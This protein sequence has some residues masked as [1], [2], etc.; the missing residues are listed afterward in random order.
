VDERPLDGT[1]KNIGA[2][3]GLPPSSIAQAGIKLFDGQVS[4]PQLVL[5]RPTMLANIDTMQAFADA[6]G[7]WMAPHGKSTMA[8]H[9][10]DAQLRAGAWGITVATA[11]QAL[12]CRA[13]GIDRILVANELRWPGD[14]ADLV[15][16][17]AGD[18]DFELLVLVDDVENVSMWADA[19]RAADLDRPVSLLAEYGW[20]G[21]RTGVR[22]LP[23]LE[24]LVDAIAAAAPWVRPAGIEGYEGIAPGASDAERAAAVESYLAAL[25]DAARRLRPRFPVPRP[26]VS[27]GGSVYFD[28]VVAHL[29]RDALPE[30]QLVLRSGGYVTHDSGLYER[31]SPL[32]AS[33]DRLPGFGRL[34]PALTLWGV[35]LSRPEPGTAIIGFGH[36]D[37]P[38]RI[39]PPVVQWLVR[40][41]ARRAVTP[42]V[43]IRRMDDQHAYV[44][45]SEA[46]D[47]L[48]GDIVG[49]GISHP[50]EAFERWRVV[51]EVDDAD[52][53]VGAIPTYF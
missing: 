32:A 40:D 43:P 18:P 11:H 41:G 10:F 49:C 15:R 6:S 2:L 42:S 8:P 5:R 35:V 22:D 34:A 52:R 25:A 20:R 33:S 12:V 9:I 36:R 38:S 14:I 3:A 17:L 53:I 37:A 26:I 39:D 13:F 31:S 45:A 44:D 50:C 16:E 21:G 1:V 19:A 4:F 23:S 29:G 7:A 48:P 46:F 27:A 51:L 28:R 30:Y 24:R 47:A